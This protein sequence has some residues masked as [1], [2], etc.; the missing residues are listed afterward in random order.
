ME[1]NEELMLAMAVFIEIPIA[2]IGTVA[3]TDRVRVV[4]CSGARRHCLRVAAALDELAA[5]V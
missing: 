4:A 3:L 2:M 5:A 1:I